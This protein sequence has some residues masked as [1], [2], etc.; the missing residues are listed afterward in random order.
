VID[1]V[2]ALKGARALLEKNGWVGPNAEP[3]CL[4]PHGRMV[5]HDDEGAHTF[6]V[7]GAL[8]A[9][10]IGAAALPVLTAIA[11]P[12]A[13]RIEDALA[14]FQKTGSQADLD[15]AFKFQEATA[16]EFWSFDSWLVAPHR[17]ADDVLRVFTLA[18]TRSKK[19]GER[20]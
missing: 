8:L 6:S 1:L 11:S 14:R 4:D 18:I 5:L 10:G 3:F 20:R 12:N 7:R 19:Q 17:T 2:A 9:H 15:L 13:A 16:S